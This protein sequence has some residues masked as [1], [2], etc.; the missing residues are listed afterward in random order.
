MC[1]RGGGLP[2]IHPDAALGQSLCWAL[3]VQVGAEAALEGAPV[4]WGGRGQVCVS[5]NRRV[6]GGLSRA[7]AQSQFQEIN[8]RLPG[9]F[10]GDPG[11]RNGGID[12][13]DG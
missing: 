9:R 4:I 1:G 5:T 7:W 13:L 10:S 11:R 2:S 3:G 6:P 12:F 8:W